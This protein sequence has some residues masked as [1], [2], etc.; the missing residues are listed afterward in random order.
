MSSEGRAAV[1]RAP[2]TIELV[3]TDAPEPA[4]DEAVVRLAASGVC[5]T[6]VEIYEGRIPVAPGRVMGHEAAGTVEDAPEGSG[7]EAGMRVVV[8]PVLSCGRCSACRDDAPNLCLRGGLLGRDRDGLFADLARVPAANCHPLPDEIPL[9]DA[10]AIQVLATVVHAQELVHVV[11]GRVAAVVGLGFTGQL[12][13]QL[14][15]VRGARVLG[16]TRSEAKRAIA[17]ELACEWTAAPAEAA[18]AAREATREGTV[19]L[20]AESSGS[21][22]ALAQAIELVRPGGTILWYGTSTATEGALPFYAVYYKEIR[23]IGARASKPRDMQI[24]IDLAAAGHVSIA[25]LVTERLGLEDVETA[26]ELS[27]R[28]ALKVMMEHR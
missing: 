4:P 8:D 6:D 28:G 2:G 3:R 16:I 24:A 18:A 10:P 11:P 25:P 13:A 21:I 5:G 9:A 22:E 17:A 15:R 20:V 7:L 19:D 23:M 12:H 14:L 26:L 1:L 27:L